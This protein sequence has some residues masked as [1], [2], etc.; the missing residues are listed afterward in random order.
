MTAAAR[1]LTPMLY[2]SGRYTP[3]KG[4]T[5]T[6]PALQIHSLRLFAEAICSAGHGLIFLFINNGCRQ[7]EVQTLQPPNRGDDGVFR[8]KGGGGVGIADVLR[9]RGASLAHLSADAAARSETV[10]GDTK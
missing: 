6:Y 2:F 4:L 10:D 9:R 8:R 7:V 5:L 3:W 1:T